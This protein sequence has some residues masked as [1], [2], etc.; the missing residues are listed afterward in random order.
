MAIALE[1]K[2]NV[3]A[4]SA[5]YP[6][7]NI[8]DN[9]GDG[10]GTPV[11]KEVY[12]DFHQFFARL[13]VEAVVTANGQP[14]NAYTGF[15]Y[16]EALKTLIST[17]VTPWITTGVVMGAGITGVNNFG[18]R[19]KN[20]RVELRGWAS[21]GSVFTTGETLFTLPVGYRPSG[22]CMFPVGSFSFLG[23]PGWQLLI[24]TNGAVN[25][26]EFN[27]TA[28]PISVTNVSLDVVSFSL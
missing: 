19:I 13:L 28:G 4:P 2:T 5:L 6:N 20:G 24:N 18:F 8:R 7:G 3:D 25:V 27:V 16:I 26:Y 1:D 12:A 23:G 14:D 21:K 10:T 17:L 9:P 22:I 15:Q 11:N